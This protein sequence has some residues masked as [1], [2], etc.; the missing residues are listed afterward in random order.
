[1]KRWFVL[2]AVAVA[3]CS[4]PSRPP[5]DTPIILISVDTLR[6]DRVRPD[7]TPNIVALS[8][9]GTTFDRAYS[10]VPLTLPSHATILTGRLPASTGVRDNV[11]YVLGPDVPTL[12]TI[13]AANGYATGGAVSSYVL[14]RS[15]GIARGFTFFD[16]DAGS[17]E[18]LDVTASRPGDR[19]MPLLQRWMDGIHSPKLF[20]FLHLYDPHAPYRAPAQF[21]KAGRSDYDAAVAYADDTVGKFVAGLK[22]RGLYDRAIIVF[23]SDHGEGLGDHGEL[24]HG[25]FVYREAIQ[26]PLIVK[27]PHSEH[28][29]THVTSLAAL[30][31]VFPTI[32]G[33]AGIAPPA[34]IDGIDLMNAKENRDR[35]VD[36]ESYYGRFHLHWH[37]LTSVITSANQF[38]EAPARELY[39]LRADPAEKH[40]VIEQNRRV[41]AALAGDLAARTKPPG[42]PANV[43]EE[44]Q[45]KLASLGYIRGSAAPDNKPYPDPKERIRFLTA[46]RTAERMARGGETVRAI[47]LLESVT[48]DAPEIV[49]AWVLLARAKEATGDPDDAIAVLRDAEKRFSD[50]PAI[51]LALADALLRAKR[52]DEARAATAGVVSAEPVLAR[53]LLAKIALAKGDVAGARSEI[54][55]AL[56]AAPHRVATLIDLAQVEKK[57]GDWQATLATLDRALAESPNPIRGLQADR[58]EAL[59]HLQRG[60]EAEEAYRK[61]V[62]RYPDDVDAWGN[63]A[64]ILAAQGRRDEARATVQQAV[65]LNPGPAAQKMAAEAM[66][67]I[68]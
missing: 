23:L 27:L 34:G 21:Q 67:V 22:Q 51:A 2:L 33:A 26:V 48:R 61:E 36:A 62:E 31:D 5:A 59:L 25:V 11:G 17:G 49:D 45:R 38:I 19:T 7:L 13:L 41:A 58:G 40:N 50:S 14:R 64:V 1:M 42:A 54:E 57:Q 68:R 63:L 46:Y 3:A 15:T 60:P 18:L 9:D 37:E 6:A 52:Y 43:D 39:D 47:P 10:H 24:D 66:D 16:D 20:A 35:Q 32:L 4:K 8:R 55:A 30:S 53:E 65:R 12:A 44:D 29:G 28:A 56:A